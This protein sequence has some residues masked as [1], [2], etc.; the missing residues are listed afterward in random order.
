M[1]TLLRD[2]QYLLD[3]NKS[4][5][6]VVAEERK[7]QD[8]LKDKKKIVEEEKRRLQAKVTKRR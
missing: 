3:E 7:K 2:K 5:E 1:A 8:S 4:L 6:L